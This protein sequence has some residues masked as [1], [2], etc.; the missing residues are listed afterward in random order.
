MPKIET[1]RIIIIDLEALCWAERS[2]SKIPEIIEIGIC[3]ANLASK[4]VERPN[5]YIVRPNNLDI[6]AFCTELTGH[7]KDSIIANGRSLEERLNTIANEYPLASC[8]WGSWGFYDRNQLERECENKRIRNPFTPNHINIK[9]LHAMF[10]GFGRG[11]GMEKALRGYNM[12]LIGRHHTGGD[13]AK[14]IGRLCLRIF[15]GQ[16]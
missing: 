15:R 12:E 3:I 7:T 5:S 4:T 8:A 14:N 6:S 10:N 2:F 16:K 11:A 1:S 13:D 9:L